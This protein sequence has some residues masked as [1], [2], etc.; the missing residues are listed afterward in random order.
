S[1]LKRA[2]RA[3]SDEPSETKEVTTARANE[4]ARLILAAYTRALR[5]RGWLDFEDLIHRPVALLEGS[6]FLLAHYR[7]RFQHVLV[8]EFQD[9]DECQY[10]LI[11]LLAPADGNLCVIGDPDQAIYGFRGAQSRFFQQFTADYP[12]AR[13]VQLR[14][15]YRS[16]RAIVQGAL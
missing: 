6:A 13:T 11:K 5:E 10:Q 7:E 12:T 15:N 4:E 14:R 1:D 9:I 3:R 8:D 16:A 2:G